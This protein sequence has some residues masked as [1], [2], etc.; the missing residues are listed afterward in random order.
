MKIIHHYSSLFIRVLSHCAGREPAALRDLSRQPFRGGPAIHH[1]E[2]R[3]DEEEEVAKP[4][5]ELKRSVLS[6]VENSHTSELT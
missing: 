5:T 3:Y 2:E 6:P 1:Q 4:L